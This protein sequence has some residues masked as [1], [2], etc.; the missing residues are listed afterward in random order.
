MI[1][2]IIFISIMTANWQKYFEYFQSQ[3]II[4]VNI[5]NHR[6]HN[7]FA[8]FF[9]FTKSKSLFFKNEIEYRSQNFCQF[10][11]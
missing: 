6:Q 9:F 7:V 3:F 8:N 11:K 1:F 10:K 5:Y 4:L 2:H